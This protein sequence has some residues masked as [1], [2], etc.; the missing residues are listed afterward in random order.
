MND[1][2]TLAAVQAAVEKLGELGSADAIARLLAREGIRGARGLSAICPL[3]VYLSR[4][5][6]KPVTVGMTSW[7]INDEFG[8]DLPDAV[9]DFIAAFD[10]DGA[11]P[12]LVHIEGR[13]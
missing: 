3:A 7:Y 8:G 5:V 9:V 2:E 13:A 1:S 4:V 11:Y 10:D 12:E 6:G